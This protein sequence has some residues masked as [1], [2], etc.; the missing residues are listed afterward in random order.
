LG[1]L[2]PVLVIAAEI[3]NGGSLCIALDK[4]AGNGELILC[5]TA[6]LAGATYFIVKEYNSIHEL[7]SGREKKSIVVLLAIFFCLWG[8][9]LA[10]TL[11]MQQSFNTPLQRWV[12]WTVYC[13]SLLLAFIL[14]AIEYQAGSAQEV[15][16]Q[17]EEAAI[18]MTEQSAADRIRKVA[19]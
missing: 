19:L 4:R 15:I 12:H 14:W 1:Q 13:C 17:M 9:I 18:D 11:L 5:S 7:R 8:V 16:R 6:I 2:G 3:W 10:S